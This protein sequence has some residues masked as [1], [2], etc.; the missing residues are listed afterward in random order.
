[1]YFLRFYYF[2]ALY[3]LLPLVIIIV[4]LHWWLRRATVYRYSLVSV[5]HSYKMKT[6]P[7][8]IIFSF[9]R[10]LTLFVLALLIAKPQL[11]DNRSTIQVE[12]IDIV[13]ALDLSGSMG[14]FDFEDDDRSR[15][16]VAKDEAIRFIE[17]RQNDAIGLVIFAQDALSRVPLTTDRSLLKKVIEELRIGIID[18]NGTKLATAIVTAANRLKH[19]KA[20]SKVMILLTDGVPTGDNLD[21]A[22]AI[23]IAQKFGI[24]IYTIGIGARDDKIMYD[25]FGRGFQMQVNKKLLRE[26]AQQTGGQFFM[27]SDARDMRTIYETID[28]LETTKM[29]VP[30]FSKYFDIFMPFVFVLI[31]LLLIELLFSTLVWFSV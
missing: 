14:L 29:E 23:K 8:R 1:M 19:S 20:N 18:Q 24:K 5:L 9:L 13:L 11:V 17:K 7:S 4:A 2:K 28:Q 3:I 10:V 26:I 25:I 22:V 31:I 21:P 27:V 6:H 15:I 30:V 12:G 16:D